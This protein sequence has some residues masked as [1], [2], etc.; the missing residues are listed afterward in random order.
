MRWYCSKCGMTADFKEEFGDYP[1][2]DGPEH[3]ICRGNSK[4]QHEDDDFEDLLDERIQE[5]E[6]E[7]IDEYGEEVDSNAA[8]FNA[9]WNWVPPEEDD[10][11]EDD[12]SK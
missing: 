9:G 4:N 12:D 1:C 3:E 10:E 8:A 6:N 7:L 11:D 5:E 2:S